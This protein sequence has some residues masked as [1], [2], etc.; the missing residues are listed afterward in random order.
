[1][2]TNIRGQVRASRV[3]QYALED[4][5]GERFGTFTMMKEKK[6]VSSTLMIDGSKVDVDD[7]QELLEDDV[8]PKVMELILVWSSKY[9]LDIVVGNSYEG[10]PSIVESVAG[11]AQVPSTA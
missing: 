4:E 1:M 7:L 11:L 5:D 9:T 6:R 2:N 8:V 3:I 10:G